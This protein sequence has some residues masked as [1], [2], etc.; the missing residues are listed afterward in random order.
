MR[1]S[2]FFDRLIGEL[3][4][5]LRTLSVKPNTIRENPASNIE[6]NELDDNERRL[7]GS[8]M[9][10]NHS[11]EIAAQGLYRGQALTAKDAEVRL[12]MQQSSEEE[13]EHLNWCET[14]LN[15]LDSRKSLFNPIWYWG[16]FTIG[17][18]AGKAGDK[19][20]LGFVEETE[21]QVVKHLNDHLNRIPANATADRAVLQQMKTDE[22]HHA[23]V[24][25]AAGA[26][27]L[28][29]IVRKIFMPATSKVMTALS[30]RL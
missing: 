21:K 12:Q 3:D 17:A 4:S 8:L 26:N 29:L 27:K 22:Q 11:G 19:W 7:T 24:A 25:N 1:K 2:S 23:D 6:N 15:A 20:S 10:I 16:S 9:R 30:Y 5:S 18:I 28:P 13:N 14:R